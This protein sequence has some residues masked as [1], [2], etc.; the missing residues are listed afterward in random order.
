M[1]LV[2]SLCFQNAKMLFQKAIIL[3]LW[4]L[5]RPNCAVIYAK[6]SVHVKGKEIVAPATKNP[7]GEKGN[8]S[9]SDY[10]WIAWEK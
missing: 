3:P 8:I 5:L 1:V 7:R 2:D 10:K 9:K 4:R 6:L